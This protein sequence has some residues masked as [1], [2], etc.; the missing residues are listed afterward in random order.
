MN[1]LNLRMKEKLDSGECVDVA[2]GGGKEIEPGVFELRGRARD[3]A[4]DSAG[5]QGFGCDFCVAAR[6]AWIWSIGKRRSDGAVL[7][8]TDARFYEHPEFECLWLR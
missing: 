7:A 5:P 8:S 3:A 1:M 6:E 4:E 2:E